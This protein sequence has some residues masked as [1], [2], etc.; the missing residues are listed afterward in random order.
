ML[1]I[2]GNQQG[3][4]SVMPTGEVQQIANL[5][6]AIVFK[7]P[8]AGGST[9]MSL[10]RDDKNINIVKFE[11]FLNK[12]KLSD[13]QT[14]SAYSILKYIVTN[15]SSPIDLSYD[16]AYDDNEMVISRRSDLGISMIAI[17]DEGDVLLSFSGYNNSNGWRI[18]YNSDN[19]DTELASLKLLS[20]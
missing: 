17:D 12:H 10:K 4:K 11:S 7:Y 6:A 5:D 2:I 14:K 16:Y 19:L 8:I 1:K 20:N 13:I 15:S 3:P 18:F 9:A